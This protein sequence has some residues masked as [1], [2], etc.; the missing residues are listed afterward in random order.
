MDNSKVL[1]EMSTGEAAAGAR[2]ACGRFEKE[3]LRVGRWI[4]P[5][6]KL[7]V[8]VTRE[9]LSRWAENFRRMLAKG[10]RVPVPYGHS[11]DPRDNAGFVTDMRVEGDSLVGVLEIPRD[12]DAARVGSVATDVSVSVNPSFVDGEG[13]SFGEVIE[14]VAITNYP[15]V[16]GQANFVP[17]AAENAPSEGADARSPEASREVIRFE[18]ARDG[19]SRQSGAGALSAGEPGSADPG[20]ASGGEGSEGAAA[21]DVA[22]VSG[23]TGAPEGTPA[24]DWDGEDR[25][26]LLWRIG[27]L[28]EERVD[29][30]VESLLLSGRISPAVEGHVRRLLSAGGERVTL[31]ATGESVSPADELR[32]ILAA[33]PAGAWVPLESKAA[34]ARTFERRSLEVSDERARDLARE[35]ARLMTKGGDKA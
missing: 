32:A 17:I 33:L 13:D 6:K 25:A 27:K 9:R 26:A 28:E 11:Y 8:D 14:H 10:I 18:M 15:V 29:R 4:H 20:S 35:N 19:A 16:S 7:V 24:P 34:A 5:A 3:L 21:A 1:W 31:S 22:Q 30:E 2:L 12:E 23:A